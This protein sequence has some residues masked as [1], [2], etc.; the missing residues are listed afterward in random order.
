[1]KYSELTEKIIKATYKV[2]NALGFGFLEK[3]YQNALAIELKKMGLDI[4]T[5]SPITVYYENEIVGEYIADIIVED[6]VILELKAVKELAEIHEVQLV[7]YLKATGIKVG[8]LINFGHS[9]QVKR[10]VFDKIKP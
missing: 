8:L 5:E 9:V 3:V 7:N 10:K 1:M 6:K 4:G 2:H